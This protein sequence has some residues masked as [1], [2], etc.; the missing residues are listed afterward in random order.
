VR[1]GVG[2]VYC[3][4]RIVLV[5]VPLVALG[6]CCAR[7]PTM[8]RGARKVKADRGKLLITWVRFLSL[9]HV[10]HMRMLAPPARKRDMF[11]RLLMLLLEMKNVGWSAEERSGYVP[12]HVAGRSNAFYPN[13]V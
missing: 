4:V 11:I 10:E 1:S 12:F 8:G 5:S 6:S 3:I 2:R 9:R 13:R 7:K